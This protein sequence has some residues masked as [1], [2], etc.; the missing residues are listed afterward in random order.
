VFEARTRHLKKEFIVFSSTVEIENV[1]GQ[2][3][4]V[5][6]WF[7]MPEDVPID[8][9]SSWLKPVSQQDQKN[10]MANASLYQMIRNAETSTY[11]VS[12]NAPRMRVMQ[13]TFKDRHDAER[14]AMRTHEALSTKGIWKQYSKIYGENTYFV[15]KASA[16]I[17]AC[18]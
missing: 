1:T 12:E 2:K 6:Y 8:T 3:D 17:S 16:P 11:P 14:F 10:R 15:P 13:I 4:W 18:D 7:K 5:T 9:F